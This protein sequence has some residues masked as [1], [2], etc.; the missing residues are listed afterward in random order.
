M[1]KRIVKRSRETL[2]VAMTDGERLAHGIEIAR[3][4][5]KAEKIETD[6]ATAAKLQKEE[7][8]GLKTTAATM[9]YE[10]LKGEVQRSIEVETIYDF[11]KGVKESVRLDTGEIIRT[12]VI[13]DSERQGT[14]DEKVSAEAEA[15]DDDEATA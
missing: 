3:L 11:Q 13:H 1:K 14:F 7:A 8:K 4:H 6:A 10:L 9:Q 12:A 5:Q 15:S 2:P